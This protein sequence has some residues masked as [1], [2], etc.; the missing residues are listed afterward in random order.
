MKKSL[1]VL[2]LVSLLGLPASA[3]WSAAVAGGLSPDAAAAVT[4]DDGAIANARIYKV[5][6]GKYRL[7]V[8]V[9]ANKLA[10]FWLTQDGSPNP[11]VPPVP[12]VPPPDPPNPPD[13]PVPPTPAKALMVVV[14]EET[15]QRTQANQEALAAVASYCKAK[16]YQR[17]FVDKD[18]IDEVG[19]AP[20]TLKPFIDRAAGKT[21]PWIMI[22]DDSRKL[23]YEATLPSASVISAKLK[24]LGG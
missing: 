19:S 24:E 8:A 1:L 9:G 2:L 6:E 5:S 7:L 12:P 21:L 13:P 23:L 14:V 22:C 17:R 11:P 20:A 10:V 4:L 3:A 16:K 15:S 18:T